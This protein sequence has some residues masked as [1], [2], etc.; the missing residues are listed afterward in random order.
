MEQI[1]QYWHME[2]TVSYMYIPAEFTL[3]ILELQL[4]AED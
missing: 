1:Q 2:S 3:P 4:V